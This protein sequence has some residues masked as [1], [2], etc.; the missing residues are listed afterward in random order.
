MSYIY[1][2]FVSQPHSN[3]IDIIKSA[4]NSNYNKLAYLQTDLE[5]QDEALAERLKDFQTK[6][7]SK[8]LIRPRA[9]VRR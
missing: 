9:G 8:S 4:S 5:E 3:A 2:V 7:S 1:I 6:Y